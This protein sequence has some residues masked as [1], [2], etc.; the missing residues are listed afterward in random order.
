MASDRESSSS[1]EENQDFTGHVNI[2]NINLS[3]IRGKQSKVNPKDNL[4]KVGRNFTPRRKKASFPANS[5]SREPVINEDSTSDSSSEEGTEFEGDTDLPVFRFESAQLQGQSDEDIDD[6]DEGEYNYVPSQSILDDSSSSEDEEEQKERKKQS[7]AQSPQASSKTL[8]PSASRIHSNRSN[9]VNSRHSRNSIFGFVHGETDITDQKRLSGSGSEFSGSTN[10]DSNRQ[11]LKGIWRKLSLAD[12]EYSDPRYY[13]E[14]EAM[15]SSKADS[16]IGRVL[17][18]SNNGLSGGGLTPGASRLSRER[19]IDEE[20]NVGMEDS[21]SVEMRKLDFTNTSDE[22]RNLILSHVPDAAALLSRP[23]FDQNLETVRETPEEGVTAFNVDKER[24]KSEGT[25]HLD[26]HPR[27][28]TDHDEEFYQPNPDIDFIAPSNDYTMM[29]DEDMHDDYVAPPKKFQAGVLSSLLKLYQNPQANKSSAST[30]SST[31]DIDTKYSE[32]RS[33]ISSGFKNLGKGMMKGGHHFKSDHLSGKKQPKEGS[34][35]SLSE[36]DEK[37]EGSTPDE[38]IEVVEGLPSFQ[39]AKPKTPKKALPLNHTIN[40][41]NN[42]NPTKVPQMR[43]KIRKHRKEQAEQLRITVHI[44]DILQRQKFIM[45]MCRALML[46]GAPT[47]RLEEYMTMTSRVLEID[48]QFMYLPGC[49]IVSFGDAATR[50][51]EVHLVKCV[52]GVN[53]SK[54]ADTHTIYKSVIHDLVGVEEAASK[55]EDLLRKKN[56]YSPWICVFLYGL[57]SASVCPFAFSGDWYDIPISFGI[58]LCVGYLQFFLSSMS[59]LYSSVFEVTASIVVSFIARAIGSIRGSSIFCFGAVVQGSLAL[60]LPGYIILCGSLELQSKNLV[61][62]SVRMFYAI[63]Y[64]LFLGFGITL[65]AALYGWVDKNSTNQAQ[66]AAD[67]K[68]DDKWRI[69]FVPLYS[70]CLALINQARWRQLPVMVAISGTGYVGTY[71]AGK[72]FSTVTE[73]TACIGAFIIG[74]LGNMYSRIGKGMAVSAMLPAIFVQVP[75]GI[76]SKST[77]LSG[78]SSANEITHSKNSTQSS[79]SDV[80]SLSFG[81]TMVEVS[82][83]ISVGLFAAALVVYPFGKKRTGL[84]TL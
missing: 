58:G 19:P 4:L 42:F 64:S 78:I 41:F 40:N 18:M 43:K 34:S 56:L 33:K 84:F 52:Q 17:N 54:L 74:I 71:F 63:I 62:G 16:F 24:E 31:Y 2:P 25:T 79:G 55:L 61:A 38:D 57:G 21:N 36:Y 75:S 82:I 44:A 6:D 70:I 32:E 29:L 28:S 83:G 51:S 5:R 67:H 37:K 46:F 53:L 80:D 8:S 22:A 50:T 47:H 76:A 7:P 77:L 30:L 10:H 23:E 39:K 1:D 81:A 20:E 9:E 27:A 60:I 73:F 35:S 11:G 65:G 49:M 45:R 59:N 12:Q 68:I 13:H 15:G 69:L 26:D 14:A 48:G 72:H 66:C 3:Q